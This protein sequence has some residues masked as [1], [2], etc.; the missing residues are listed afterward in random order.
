[1]RGDCRERY[2]AVL[3]GCAQYYGLRAHPRPTITRKR[4]GDIRSPSVRGFAARAN[5]DMDLGTANGVYVK[6]SA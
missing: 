6:G 2:Y 3:F 5:P 1:M 4:L